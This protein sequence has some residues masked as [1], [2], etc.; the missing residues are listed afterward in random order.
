MAGDIGT[1]ASEAVWVPGRSIPVPLQFHAVTVRPEWVDYNDH[2]S[3]W[4]YLLVFGDNADAL[5][6]FIGIDEAYRA[7]G[8]SL[9]TAETHLRHLREVK[10]GQRLALTLTVLGHDAKRLHVL[11]EMRADG[12]GSVATAEQLLLHVDAAAGRVAPFGAKVADR[13]RQIAAAHARLG[14]P[15]YAGRCMRIPER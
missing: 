9:Y 13:L 11:H 2:L 6:R 8:R 5:F 15:D 14:V 3:E 7:T 12:T 4:A 10:V 1:G